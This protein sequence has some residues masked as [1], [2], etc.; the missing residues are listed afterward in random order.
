MMMDVPAI[1]RVVL[2]A[3]AAN[4]ELADKSR[5]ITALQ[6][7]IDALIKRPSLAPFRGAWMNM[8]RLPWIQ[9]AGNVGDTGGPSGLPAGKFDMTPG[10]EALWSV[11]ERN[12]YRYRQEQGHETDT[13]FLYMADV[14]A[15]TATDVRNCHCV[16]FD[17]FNKFLDGWVYNGALQDRVDVPEG[18]Y[19]WDRSQPTSGKRWVRTDTQSTVFNPMQWYTV[20]AEFSCDLAA[21]TLT[22]Y[23]FSIDGSVHPVNATVPAVPDPNRSKKLTTGFQLDVNAAKAPFNI[24]TRAMHIFFG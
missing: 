6:S 20:A 16:E 18:W 9:P 1:N 19:V 15:P 12:G 3:L 22:T 23:W 17:C 5:T 8:Q 2:D 21:H 7:Q 11:A 14:L 4:E 10:A 13:H 24:K